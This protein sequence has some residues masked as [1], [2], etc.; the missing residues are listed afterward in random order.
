MQDATTQT[1]RTPPPVK[2]G[3]DPIVTG[4]G[5]GCGIIVGLFVGLQLCGLLYLL[6]P[7]QP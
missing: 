5:I 6:A 1:N 3:R 4:I 7:T 2:K